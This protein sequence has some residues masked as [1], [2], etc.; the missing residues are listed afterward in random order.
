MPIKRILNPMN[1]LI[2][3]LL[4]TLTTVATAQDSTES[5]VVAEING[6]VIT[7]TELNQLIAQQTGG[8]TDLPPV[9]RQR[10]LDETINLIL[11]A[12]AGEAE[13]VEPTPEAQAQLTNSRRQ[14][15]AQ[16]FVRSF[17]QMDQISD[18]ALRARYEEDYGAGAP[19]EYSARHI[20]VSERGLAEEIIELIEGGETFA[21]MASQHSQDGSAEDGGDLGWF[22]RGDM[23]ASFADAVVAL[24][25]G[26]MTTEP[27]ETRFGWHVIQLDDTR[28]GS[29]PAFEAVSQQL[30]MTM[31][32]E[33]IEARLDSLRESADIDYRADWAQ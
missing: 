30:A 5:A 22:T 24:E 18:D 7:Q 6:E 14:A 20:L 1:L 23:V 2:A 8:G 26:E 9:Q 28:E 10:F 13:S 21:E 17:A 31:V 29:V 19:L 33:R 25:P 15:L 4:G 3:G 32:N 11:L 12:Q 16:A 27:V